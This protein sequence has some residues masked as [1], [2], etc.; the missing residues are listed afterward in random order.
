MLGKIDDRRPVEW[1]YE[2]MY[3]CMYVYMYV[4]TNLVLLLGSRFGG[5]MDER[6][7][8]VTLEKTYE[9]S[10]VEDSTTPK[11]ALPPRRI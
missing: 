3:V 1:L 7:L 11:Q 2:C 9:L 5:N 6:R 10:R 4:R 8:E